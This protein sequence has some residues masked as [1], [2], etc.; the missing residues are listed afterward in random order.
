MLWSVLLRREIFTSRR[1]PV[2]RYN[3]AKT[4][5][6]RTGKSP[7]MSLPFLEARTDAGRPGGPLLMKRK[8]CHCSGRRWRISAS[9]HL[10][11]PGRLIQ[12]SRPN[13]SELAHPGPGVFLLGLILLILLVLYSDTRVGRQPDI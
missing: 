10:G 9:A 12:R 1:V 11:I 6:D 8:P 2:E 7:E 3:Q 4:L 5:W 13:P